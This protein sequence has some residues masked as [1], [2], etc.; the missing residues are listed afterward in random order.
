[1]VT[2][3]ARDRGDASGDARGETSGEM[4]IDVMVKRRPGDPLSLGDARRGAARRSGAD[5]AAARGDAWSEERS[6]DKKP[7]RELR[8]M[9]RWSASRS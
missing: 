2:K 9:L 1:M 4:A 3:P 6:G 7:L 8:G 5:E